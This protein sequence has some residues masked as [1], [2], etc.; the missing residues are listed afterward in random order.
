M[1]RNGVLD[2][3][4]N[5]SILQTIDRLKSYKYALLAYS[6]STNDTKLE[7]LKLLIQK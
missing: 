4:F 5:L 7:V 1:I 6:I 2:A 3:Y